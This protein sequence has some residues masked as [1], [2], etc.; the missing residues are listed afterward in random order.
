MNERRFHEIYRG[1]NIDYNPDNE[2]ADGDELKNVH[3]SKDGKRI[4]STR[5]VEAAYD[6]IDVMK[7][8]EAQGAR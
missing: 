1:Y 6:T 3:I 7:R 4:A 2:G 8:E 5:G